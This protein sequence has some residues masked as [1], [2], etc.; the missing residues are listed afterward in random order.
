MGAGVNNTPSFSQIK[1]NR[2]T[3]VSGLRHFLPSWFMLSVRTCRAS[4]IHSRWS[5]CRG[6]SF[7]E[8]PLI[9][10]NSTTLGANATILVLGNHFANFFKNTH[11]SFL[12]YEKE[13]TSLANHSTPMFYLYCFL[14]LCFFSIRYSNASLSCFV[15]VSIS[16]C[17]SNES[18]TN[19][20]G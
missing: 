3:I 18:L 10:I 5:I 1:Q 6:C 15:I 2:F 19:K 16:F 17:I 4:T 20:S 13:T 12:L 7:P 14:S 11:I 9:H 8:E